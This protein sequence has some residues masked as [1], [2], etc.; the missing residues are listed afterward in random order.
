MKSISSVEYRK[1]GVLLQAISKEE[2]EYAIMKEN[3]GRFRLAYTSPTLEGNLYNDLGP[4]GEGPMT[5]DILN[6]QEQFHNQPEVKEIFFLFHNSPHHTISSHITP[7]QWI[8]H[9]RHAKERTASSFSGLHF[10]HYKAHTVKKEI[11][12][13]KCKLINLA[14]L[15]G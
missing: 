6:S 15:S 12:E 7:E 4:S 2:V 3:S 9:W 8:E 10:G 13:I 11:A 14:L 5:N 1:N